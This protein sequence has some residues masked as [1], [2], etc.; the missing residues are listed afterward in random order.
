[1]RDLETHLHMFQRDPKIRGDRLYCPRQIHQRVWE[2]LSKVEPVRTSG[3]THRWLMISQWALRDLL[4]AADER[5]K[6]QVILDQLFHI[7]HRPE[8]ALQNFLP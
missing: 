2:L 6:Q 7:I 1:M 5:F 8:S 3:S 4:L